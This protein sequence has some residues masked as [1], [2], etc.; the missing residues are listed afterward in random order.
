MV[1]HKKG[2]FAFIKEKQPRVF[3]SGCPLHL[4]HIAAKKAA[5]CLPPIDDVLVDIFYYF[6]KSEKRKSEFKGTQVLYDVEQRKML[7]HVC[8][9]W[10]SIARYTFKTI[11]I[12]FDICPTTI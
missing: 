1:G 3:L 12:S 5:Q 4:V 7:K 9:R 11:F 2:V 6:N 8:T 10:L